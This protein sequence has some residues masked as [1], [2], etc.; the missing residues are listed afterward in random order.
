MERFKYKIGETTLDYT[1]EEKDLGVIMDSSLKF[2]SHI[3]SKVNKANQIMGLIRR[4][5]I[6]LDKTIFNRL[7]KAL[8]RPHLEF[9]HTIWFPS[10][11]KLKTLIENVQ[12]RATKQLA[13]CKGMEYEERLKY[14]DLPCLEYRRLR[15]D[16]IEVYKMA[17]SHY[18]EEIPPP[19]TIHQG[20]QHP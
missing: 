4:S 9:A 12:R 16:M 5:F 13:C 3:I 2:E 17:N 10:L 14:L 19:I 8:V 11:K 20:M 7:F 15:G 18:D 6:H 1:D